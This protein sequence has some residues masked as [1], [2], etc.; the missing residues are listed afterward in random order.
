[1]SLKDKSFAS[2]LFF[3]QQLS[4]AFWVAVILILIML[5]PQRKVRFSL[6]SE[7]WYLPLSFY[8]A[9]YLYP[10]FL[11]LP[12]ISPAL[13]NLSAVEQSVQLSEKE[14]PAPSTFP[15]RYQS[16]TNCST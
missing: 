7:A 16:D 15:Q 9:V 1:M 14:I 11:I 5:G 12:P 10:V 3:I 6:T 13:F 8:A 4:M 2:V